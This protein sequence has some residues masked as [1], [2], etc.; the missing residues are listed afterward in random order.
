MGQGLRARFL[1]ATSLAVLGLGACGGSGD[2]ALDGEHDAFPTGKADGGIDAGS[3]EAAAV[4][5]LVNDPEVDLGI[6]DHDAGLHATA[7]RNI[8]AH[9]NGDDETVGTA[10]D[11]AF[12]SLAELDAISF[13]GPAA[14]EQ[15]LR[16][17]IDHGYLQPGGGEGDASIDVVFSPQPSESTHNA[18]VAELIGTAEHSIDIAMYSFSNAAVK[19]ALADAVERGVQVRMVFEMAN[20]DRKLSGDALQASASGELEAMGIDVRWVNKIMHHKFAIVDGPRDDLSR[21][22]TATITSGS[23]N[24]SNS[25]GTRYDE[26]T[27]FI[28]GYPE[29]ALRMQR[30]F[31]LLWVHSKDLAAQDFEHVLSTADI[32]DGDI[33]DQGDLHVH[34]TSDN[35]DVSGTTF[36]TTGRNEVSDQL[37]EAIEGATESIHVASGHLRLRPVAEALI[38]KKQ[39]EPEMDIRVYLDGQEYISEFFHDEQNAELEVCLAAATTEA[40]IRKCTDKGFLFGFAVGEAGIDVRYKYYAYR[41]HYTYAEQMHHKYIVIDGDELWTG[42]FNLSDNALHNTIEN[43]MVFRGEAFA[44]LVDDFETNFESMWETG[45]PEGDDG[46]DLLAQLTTEVQTSDVVP[47]VFDS[48]ALT[49]QEVTDLKELIRDNCPQIN[50]TDFRTHPEN[51]KICIK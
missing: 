21:A 14:L 25:A 48:M 30:E 44:D 28:T 13:V 26:N 3:P 7:A 8:I 34:F 9:R 42:S 1:L 36:S 22:A 16:Y 19:N 38:A 17:A 11:D 45:R 24:W 37:V 5:A 41:W 29:M 39:A 4:L 12:D 51:H 10:D 27:L 49:W 18:R 15:L 33:E 2:D 47:L 40:Q 6:L 46:A 32:D 35:F 31:D 43:M 20:E 50:S 23:A